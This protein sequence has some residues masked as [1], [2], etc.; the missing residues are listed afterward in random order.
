MRAIP[1]IQRGRAG[2]TLVEL[3]LAIVITAMVSLGVASMMT[4]VA[5]VTEADREARSALLRSLAVREA[6]RAYLEE[7]L[8]VLQVS[9]DGSS[10]AVWLEDDLTPGC[11]NLLEVRVLTFDA[12]EGTIVASR[13]EAP[14]AWHPVQKQALNII[15]AASG[16]I[17][18]TFEGFEPLGMVKSTTLAAGIADVEWALSSANPREARRARLRFDLLAPAPVDADPAEVPT[19]AMLVAFGLPEHRSPVR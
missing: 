8:A 5:T 9:A 6:L 4:T 17:F 11:A 16:D 19:T 7:A 13:V 14:D 10:I 3:L 18:G 1:F 2:V 15:M 12:D